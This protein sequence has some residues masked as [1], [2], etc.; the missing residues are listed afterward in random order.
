MSTSLS[1]TLNGFSTTSSVPPTQRQSKFGPPSHPQVT[2]LSHIRKE[3]KWSFTVRREPVRVS[4]Q[5]APGP[6]E[7][8]VTRQNL[9]TTKFKS[10]P[11]VGFGSAG[12]WT[13]LPNHAPPEGQMHPC[14]RRGARHEVGFDGRSVLQP[15]PRELDKCTPGPGS[16]GG[17]FT[18]FGY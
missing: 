7:Y 5:S 3:P 4:C 2:G 17:H 18:S 15:S 6:G 16:Y 11:R 8:D 1:D 9:Q 14:V 13:T 12:W 10:T